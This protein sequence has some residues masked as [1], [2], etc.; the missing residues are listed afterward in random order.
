MGKSILHVSDG[1]THYFVYSQD[2]TTIP[3]AR[4]TGCEQG[5]C[6]VYQCR[7]GYIVSPDR[8]TCIQRGNSGYVLSDEDEQTTFL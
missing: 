4:K 3:S 5:V 2:C 7:E 1:S 8:T 6:Q